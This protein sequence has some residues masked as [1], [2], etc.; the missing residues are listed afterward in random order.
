MTGEFNGDFQGKIAALEPSF[1]FLAERTRVEPTASMMGLYAEYFIQQGLMIEAVN[2][3][4]RDIVIGWDKPYW[5]SAEYIAV[6]ARQKQRS[7]MD[8]IH[9][10]KPSA[11]ILE[12]WCESEAQRRWDSR[13]A[14]AKEWGE[15]NPGTLRVLI[16][17]I[18]GD[19][20]M[21]V[22]SGAHQWLKESQTYRTHFRKGAA[23]GACIKRAGEEERKAAKQ[24]RI[25]Q[26]ATAAQKMREDAMLGID[27]F[28]TEPYTNA[29]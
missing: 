20:K 8:E 27:N 25:T 16:E 6:R 23:V 21:L 2:Q 22:Q 19:I 29:L 12:D 9:G 17:G 13:K 1:R 4:V 11:R 28:Q 3:T 7:T 18:D 14:M 15:K 24:L 10:I 26:L 5:P